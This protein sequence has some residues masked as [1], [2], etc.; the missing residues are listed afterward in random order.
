M[1][2]GRHNYVLFKKEIITRFEHTKLSITCGFP[3]RQKTPHFSSQ[4]L[5]T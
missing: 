5:K 2:H 4:Y 3:Q 1:K